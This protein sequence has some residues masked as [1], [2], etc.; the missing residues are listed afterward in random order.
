M[1]PDVST[2]PHVVVAAD[3]DDDDV[4]GVPDG[5]DGV[6]APAARGDLVVLD[7]ALKGARFRVAGGTGK[8]RIVQGGGVVP[9]GKPIARGAALQGVAPGMVT[10]V[11]RLKNWRERTIVVDV[12]GVTF[13]DTSGHPVDATRSHASMERNPPSLP[14]TPLG[15]PPPG[16]PADPS[17]HDALRAVLVV[18][19]AST[20]PID[21]SVVSYSAGGIELDALDHVP[22]LPAPCDPGFTAVHCLETVPLRFVVDDVD[23]AHP[24]VVDRSLRAEVGGAIVVRTAGRKQAIRVMGPRETP[25]GPIGRLR[26]HVRAFV[27]RL[28]RGGPPA[29]GGNDAGAVAMLRAELAL[30]SATWGQCGL[31]FGN[32]ARQQVHVVDPPP[33]FL[34]AIGDDLGLPASGGEIR[35][36]VDGRNVSVPVTAGSSVESVAHQVAAALG[37]ASFVV[38]ES[39]NPRIGPGA[40]ASIDLLVRRPNGHPA[41]LDARAGG[42]LSTDATLSVRIGR[43][44]PA[45]GVDHFGDTDAVAGTLE[46]R[47]LL[48][49]LDDGDPSTIE[50]VVVPFFGGSGRIGES[51]IADESPS[52]QNA[53][54][55]DRAGV[56]AR[57]SSFT[58]AHELGHIFLHEA[59]HPDDYGVDT[60]TL[61]M[62]SDASDASPF[63][64]RR[65][66]L[67]QCA[68]MLRES[69]PTSRVPLVAPW[70]LTPL[71]LH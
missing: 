16:G 41:V 38:T 59:G 44:D 66:T 25:A 64:P 33:P 55:L 5:R 45:D 65:I 21:A 20:A 39:P 60:P 8:V 10:L 36:R 67:D 42:P 70:P 4:D 62:D 14:A 22:L 35:L 26:A 24:L 61:L 34:L 15:A 53:V 12:R 48:K 30:A 58:L 68:E 6:V 31:S 13:R 17:D 2:A 9:W 19:D 51:F 18:P 1:T 11:A 28:T 32:A 57:R 37:R 54:L 69:G 56:R 43:V 49:S 63:G 47:T 27:V 23:R 50:V 7:G 46:E 71:N 52:M 40:A 29:I 3:L